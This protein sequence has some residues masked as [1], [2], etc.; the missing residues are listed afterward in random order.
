MKGC[1]R[2]A[3]EVSLLICLFWLIFLGIILFIDNIILGIKIDNPYIRALFRNG[4][5]FSLCGLWLY[6]IYKT[7]KAYYI[8]LIT[9]RVKT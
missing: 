2:R 3:L 9:K 1:Y 7:F 5:S 4:V 6:L 8:H